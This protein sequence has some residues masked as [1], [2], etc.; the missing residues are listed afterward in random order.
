MEKEAKYT[1]FLADYL[2][3]HELPDDFALIEGFDDLFVATYIDRE[4]GFETEDLFGIKLSAKAAMV[5]PLYKARIDQLTAAWEDVANAE[6]V[7]VEA[8]QEATADTLNVAAQ[9]ST[10]T[11]LPL[12]T[13]SALPNTE[14]KADA[15][16][17]T[18][19][20][21]NSRNVTRTEGGVTTLEAYDV[22]ERLHKDV[23]NVL[24][25]LLRE[26]EPLFMGV[27]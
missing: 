4:I 21:N 5:I 22:V 17:N 3:T 27:F 26:F 14:Q 23:Y 8:T 2:K 18:S 7:V 13:T 9:K 20:R 15:Y 25:Y 6:K 19:A 16:T 1:E 10:M 12:N 24:Y 11:E